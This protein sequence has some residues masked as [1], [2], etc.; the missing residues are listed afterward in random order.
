MDSSGQEDGRWS[1]LTFPS[2]ESSSSRSTT[3]ASTRSNTRAGTS[4]SSRK[5]WT[6]TRYTVSTVSPKCAASDA[7]GKDVGELGRSEIE[8]GL[9]QARLVRPRRRPGRKASVVTGSEWVRVAKRRWPRASSVPSSSSCS[10]STAGPA[11][12]IWRWPSSTGSSP[13]PTR[14]VATATATCSPRR[15]HGRKRRSRRVSHETEALRSPQRPAITAGG[16]TDTRRSEPLRMPISPTTNP[17]VSTQAERGKPGIAS[18][19]RP[20]WAH[21]RSLGVECTSAQISTIR[22]GRRVE[23]GATPLSRRRS[24]MIDVAKRTPRPRG[25]PHEPGS[26]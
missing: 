21:L 9:A 6:S 7:T 15:L 20:P 26:E 4:S 12:S 23:L 19:R 25:G 24:R 8:C 18:F 1:F 10:T 2:A 16:R 3:G 5:Q 22:S 14:G 13:G 17:S 11:A